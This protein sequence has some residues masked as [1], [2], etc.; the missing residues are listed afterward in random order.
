MRRDQTSN[1]FK[2]WKIKWHPVRLCWHRHV[3]CL[4]GTL[5]Y[6]WDHSDLQTGVY[7]QGLLFTA[8]RTHVLQ[9][10]TDDY[11]PL[12]QQLRA[13]PNQWLTCKDISSSSHTNAAYLCFQQVSGFTENMFTLSTW[14]ALLLHHC[15]HVNAIISISIM[16]H[17]YSYNLPFLTR[18]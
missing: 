13:V 1:F 8:K 7:L 2:R 10:S 15:W 9:L 5:N 17:Y 18:M 4:L 14:Q 11:H 16:L 12:F 6:T 3:H